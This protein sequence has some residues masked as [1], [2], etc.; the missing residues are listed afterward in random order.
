[1]LRYQWHGLL[2]HAA[3]TDGMFWIWICGGE[4]GGVW[5]AGAG[6]ER[7]VKYDIW[8]F[9]KERKYGYVKVVELCHADRWMDGGFMGLSAEEGEVEVKMKGG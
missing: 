2:L 7:W 1:M 9:E 4:I 5:E 8:V 6:G 3:L